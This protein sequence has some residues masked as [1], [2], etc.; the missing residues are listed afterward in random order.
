MVA[1]VAVVVVVA[2]AAVAVA[3]V[4]VAVAVLVLVELAVAVALAVVGAL[5]A[6]PLAPPLAPPLAL[7]TSAPPPPASRIVHGASCLLQRSVGPQSV[8]SHSTPRIQY[9]EYT[10]PTPFLVPHHPSRC[11]HQFS[12]YHRYRRTTASPTPHH[13]LTTP[14][15]PPHHR[16]SPLLSPSLPPLSHTH[17]HTH[18]H[19]PHTHQAVLHL[20]DPLPSSP[21]AALA[22]LRPHAAKVTHDQR[23]AAVTAL[24]RYHIRC[25]IS[26]VP[27][28]LYHIRCVLSVGP[29]CTDPV[30]RLVQHA[31]AHQPTYQPLPPNT[32]PTLSH[33][34]ALI[35]QPE[36]VELVAF[37]SA[38]LLALAEAGAAAGN[39]AAAAA[40]RAGA[41]AAASDRG[42]SGSWSGRSSA[43]ASGSGSG[44][45]SASGS[46]SGRGS[47]GGGASAQSSVDLSG[48][49]ADLMARVRSVENQIG[50][51]VSAGASYG[52]GGTGGGDGAS[53]GGVADDSLLEQRERD[54]AGL[55]KAIVHAA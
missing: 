53:G 15:P 25:I 52:G 44:S 26:V 54:V 48:S 11:P 40:A 35:A 1:V 16:P 32:P 19:T 10:Q 41:G 17:T 49:Q 46:A 27:Y 38:C 30:T 6:A 8:G 47:G 34:R 24:S 36:S 23:A 18:T 21:D 2:V 5:A 43:S 13:S 29:W 20:E 39:T 7:L 31:P 12:P 50:D 28:S 3:V 51:Q 14:S 55:L 42:A 33:P 37:V 22:L 9:L 4:A 45:G